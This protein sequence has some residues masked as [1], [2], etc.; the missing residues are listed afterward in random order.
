[1]RFYKKLAMPRSDLLIEQLSIVYF[2]CIART[3]ITRDKNYLTY[4]RRNLNWSTL[5]SKD[6]LSVDNNI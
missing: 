6:K 1:M 3:K 4:Q 5:K 2:I